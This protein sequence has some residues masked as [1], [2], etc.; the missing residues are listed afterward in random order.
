M[1]KKRKEIM[2]LNMV[3]I[4]LQLE[5]LQGNNYIYYKIGEKLFKYY[6]LNKKHTQS[7]IDLNKDK[8]ENIK[9]ITKKE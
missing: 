4:A 5:N 6:D 7:L 1:T 8:I 2:L 9:K 3:Y